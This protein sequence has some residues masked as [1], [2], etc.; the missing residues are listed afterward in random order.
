MYLVA[1][2]CFIIRIYLN[3]GMMMMT[4]DGKSNVFM[5]DMVMKLILYNKGCHTDDKIDRIVC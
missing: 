5:T 4:L 1:S 3:D 2:V